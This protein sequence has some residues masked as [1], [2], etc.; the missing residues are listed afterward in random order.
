MTKRIADDAARI[1][2]QA[3]RP[4]TPSKVSSTA[5]QVKL[6][7]AAKRL[8]ADEFSSG[9]SKAL[10]VKS[11][12]LGTAQLAVARPSAP[13]PPV[14][15]SPADK[16]K[17]EATRLTTLAKTDPKAAADQLAKSL[18]NPDPA[19]HAA[20]L[21]ASAAVVEQIATSL[22]KAKPEVVQATVASLGKASQAAGPEGAQAL[23]A[24]FAKGLE[25]GLGGFSKLA[26]LLLPKGA[27]SAAFLNAML[28]TPGMGDFVT[29]MIAGAKEAGNVPLLKDLSNLIEASAQLANQA[30]EKASNKVDQLNAELNSLVQ[31]FGPGD[32]AKLQAAVA[33]FKDRHKDE[34]AALEAAGVALTNVISVAGPILKNAKDLPFG[35]ASALLKSLSLAPK[36]LATQAGQEAL[37]RALDAQGRGE[38]SPLLDTVLLMSKDPKVREQLAPLMTQALSSRIA[39]LKADGRDA[40]AHALIDS[41]SKNAAL[42]GV[43]PEQLKDVQT[44]LHDTL[45]G[46]PG[47]VER[48][49]LAIGSVS[50]FLP[51]GSTAAN[52]LKALGFVV[53]VAGLGKSF[54]GFTDAE[55]QDQ[56]GTL[57]STLGL[58]VDGA[59]LAIKVFGNPA[60]QASWGKLFGKVSTVTGVIGA[61]VG[62]IDFAR[63]AENGNL[64]DTAVSGLNAAAGVLL[65]IPGGQVAGVGL[66]IASFVLSEFLGARRQ[67][68]AEQ[69]SEADAKAFLEAAGLDPEF[70]KVFANLDNNKQN[71]GPF[72]EQVAK[73]LGLTRDELF[74]KLNASTG[75]DREKLLEQFAGLSK[76]AEVL[77]DFGNGELPIFG[78]PLTLEDLEGLP[79]FVSDKDKQ[80]IVDAVNARRAQLADQVATAIEPLLD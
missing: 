30:F 60:A 31:G 9:R 72:I 32:E 34:Y 77:Q 69:A 16:A 40:E 28:T 38:S 43:S 39:A 75:K 48:L 63:T 4:T 57:A 27:G 37:G 58:G 15:V 61:V 11:L 17:A 49:N 21:D 78:P 59:A 70:A 54:E 53:G 1:A 29:G 51:E 66:A 44:A 46:K 35:F 24:A 2:A 13:T 41:L 19:F 36:A 45:D 33:A 25:G 3:R 56:V 73:E 5:S 65:L 64:G 26:D 79:D 71:I 80:R 20:L 23:G 22:K 6:S 74:E 10:R 62:V 52:S 8:K 55:L 68:E 50:P 7:A 14:T 12:A 76:A 18:E 67:R 42:F 47:A